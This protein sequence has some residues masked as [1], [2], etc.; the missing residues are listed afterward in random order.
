MSRDYGVGYGKPPRHTRFRKGASGNPRGRPKHTKNLKTDLVEELR[1]LI[2]VREGN[3]ERHISKQRAM[4]KSLTAKAIKGD[5][6]AANILLNMIMRVLEPEASL[7]SDEDLDTAD[8][9]ILERFS[10]RTIQPRP[11]IGEVVRDP[12][13][14]KAR[15]AADPKRAS[16]RRKT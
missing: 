5:A 1:E 2:L 8:R 6:R 9:A 14:S 15:A 7:D 10:M 16:T 13:G 4:L 3:R 12:R 11:S